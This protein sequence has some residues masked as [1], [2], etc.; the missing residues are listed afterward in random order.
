M[1]N[2]SM[3]ILQDTPE[4]RQSLVAKVT[5]TLEIR[6]KS[7]KEDFDA[8][9]NMVKEEFIDESSILQIFYDLDVKRCRV[10]LVS[11]SDAKGVVINII[12]DKFQK[13]NEKFPLFKYEIYPSFINNGEDHYLNYPK[14]FCL[15]NKV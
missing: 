6:T 15:F 13:I 1:W 14:M 4:I 8:F 10:T 12:Y 9:I 11:K 2:N 7:L 3:E 5:E